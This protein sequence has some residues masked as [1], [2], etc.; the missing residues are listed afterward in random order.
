MRW[1][2]PAVVLGLS[3]LLGPVAADAQP[4]AKVRRLRVFPR[5]INAHEVIE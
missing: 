5:D 2:G 4:A 3:V 1:I